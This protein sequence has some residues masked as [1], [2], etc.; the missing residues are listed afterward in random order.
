MA[1]LCY[2]GIYMEMV[3]IG[4]DVVMVAVGYLMKMVVDNYTAAMMVVAYIE[5]VC[6]NYYCG[7]GNNL[8]AAEDRDL[9]GNSMENGRLEVRYHS[10]VVEP[11]SLELVL[12]I[13]NLKKAVVV[14]V[15]DKVV[16]TVMVQI[17]A[18]AVCID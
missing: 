2:S 15:I 14:E 4:I 17:L 9:E 8:V 5:A 16:E 11:K 7:F 10:L 1:A 6:M 18:E 3:L 12:V 13:G